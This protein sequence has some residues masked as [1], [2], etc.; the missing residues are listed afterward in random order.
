MDDVK[1]LE[2]AVG[3]IVALVGGVLVHLN[4]RVIALEG[5]FGDM[6]KSLREGL[7]KDLERV[8][9][10]RDRDREQREKDLQSASEFR[11]RMLTT[12]GTMATK[13]DVRGLPSKDDLRAVE[14]RVS[15]AVRMIMNEK[16]RRGDV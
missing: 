11:E 9:E 5:Q 14:E 7:A 3:I 12:L 4:L 15:G 10:A 16:L 1:W 2:I 6:V 8:W 13:E